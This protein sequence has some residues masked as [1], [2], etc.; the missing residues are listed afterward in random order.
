ML[1]PLIVAPEGPPDQ[2]LQIYSKYQLLL[3]RNAVSLSILAGGSGSKKSVGRGGSKKAGAEPEGC[4]GLRDI[5]SLYQ[6]RP[7]AVERTYNLETGPRNVLSA[8]ALLGAGP[9]SARAAAA[10]EECWYASFILQDD[11]DPEA[12]SSTLSRLPLTEPAFLD[13]ARHSNCV[14]FFF[15][16]N[17]GRTAM[18]GRPEHTD[19]ISHSGTWHLQASGTKVW[20]VRPSSGAAWPGGEVP[21]LGGGLRR[22]R[23]EV[24]AGDLFMIN[25]SA[26]FHETEIP[27]TTEG[28]EG[29]SLSY[30][31]DF[32]LTGAHSDCD[33]TNVEGTWAAEPIDAHALILR[34]P[35]LLCV[36]VCVCV[37]CASPCTCFA[38]QLIHRARLNTWA[39]RRPRTG[40][41]L[42]RATAASALCSARVFS[43]QWRLEN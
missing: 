15:G 37:F 22:L 28:R 31:R 25:T 18:R 4:F 5:R 40:G 24:N 10:A 16:S 41:S 20:Y 12:F 13:E 23:V 35:P 19:Q 1:P 14:W 33:M 42:W 26:W 32:H 21:T 29:I 17:P 9:R 3:V 38:M 27:C 30:A 7:G 11:H 6:R 2:R 36:Q 34:E 8:A 43:W 39:G